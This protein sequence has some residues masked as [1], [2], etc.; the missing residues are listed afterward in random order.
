MEFLSVMFRQQK[1]IVV[2]GDVVLDEYVYGSV[3]RINPEAPVPVFKEDS[4]KYVIGGAANV[5]NNIKALKGECVL[6]SRIGRD[7]AGERL[8]KILD[9]KGIIH[10]FIEDSKVITPLKTRYVAQN[11]QLLRKDKEN[12]FDISFEQEKII[13]EQ[14][15]KD[16]LVLISDYEKGVI[17]KGLM[18]ALKKTGATVIAD[19]KSI[20]KKFEGVYL[21]KPNMKC[22]ANYIGR[23]SSELEINNAAKKMQNDFGVNILLTRGDEGISLFEKGKEAQ[24]IPAQAKEVYDVTGAGDTTIATLALGLASGKKLDESAIIAN[25]AAGIVVGKFGTSVVS[26]QELESVLSKKNVKIKD[27]TKIKEIVASL[28][29]ESK[30][31]VFT[32]GCFDIL[33]IGH[34]R[35]LK[36]AK[37]FGDVLILGLN[38]DASVKRFKGPARPIIPEEDRAEILSSLE[39][40]DYIVFFDED[41][42]CRIIDEI[43]P[44][45]HVKGGD[46]NPDDFIKM[47]EAKIVRGYGGEVKIINIVDGRST[48][49]IINKIKGEK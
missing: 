6:V 7:E 44:D 43:K 26:L 28:K 20:S 4:T 30:R 12:V 14:V 22:F 41:N 38:T 1:K 19:P 49:S 8:K 16:C 33:H 37:G 29:A 31:I 18:D 40:V 45:I 13:L 36:E 9:E 25:I 47:P 17:T 11:Q 27:L 5:A 15:D 21:I 34:T 24:H 46:Y 42:P 23:L 10:F 39:C 35:L 32:N 2:I 3:S 48:S